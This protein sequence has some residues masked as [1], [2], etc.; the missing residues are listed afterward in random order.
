[1]IIDNDKDSR[2]NQCGSKGF[3]QWPSGRIGERRAILVGTSRLKCGWKGASVQR[4]PQQ[5]TER[6][7]LLTSFGFSLGGMEPGITSIV[8]TC[9]HG[10][11][12]RALLELWTIRSH[13]KVEILALPGSYDP[14][15]FL[16]K[17]DSEMAIIEAGIEKLS[18]T[19]P[20]RLAVSASVSKRSLRL[21]RRAARC[22]PGP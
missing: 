11:N 14:S 16:A 6:F 5:S 12:R 10:G 20:L 9:V 15:Q 8:N 3:H 7:L 4:F 22:R 1:M 13:L 21:L 18:P 17:L 19:P 2:S